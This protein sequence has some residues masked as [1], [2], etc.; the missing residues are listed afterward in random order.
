MSDKKLI[1]AGR[2]QAW[3]AKE[4]E[5]ARVNR[6]VSEDLFDTLL[7]QYECVKAG[8]EQAAADLAFGLLR[9]AEATSAL[10][11]STAE[12]NAEAESAKASSD[13]PNNTTT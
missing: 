1:T 5:R 13:E 4:L 8:Y 3:R 11:K 6:A 9:E 10:E 12:F 2:M 7:E